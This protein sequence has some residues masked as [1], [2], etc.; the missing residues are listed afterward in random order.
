[1]PD[2]IELTRKSH[3][4]SAIYRSLKWRNQN[5]ILEDPVND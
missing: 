3:I 1:M 2:L 5:M 4:N